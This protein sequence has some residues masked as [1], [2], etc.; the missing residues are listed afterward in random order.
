MWFIEKIKVVYIRLRDCIPSQPLFGV[1]MRMS[2]KVRD[3]R[4]FPPCDLKNNPTSF[5]F[6]LCLTVMESRYSPV[7]N[8]ELKM[9]TLCDQQAKLL[10]NKNHSNQELSLLNHRC[11]SPLIS[12]AKKWFTILRCNRTSTK[13]AESS[14][15]SVDVATP[16]LEIATPSD[17]W[18]IYVRRLETESARDRT[19]HRLITSLSEVV[20]SKFELTR[21]E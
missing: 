19:D 14:E 11:S 2:Q 6:N 12:K 4:N 13:D 1:L 8:R 3:F 16:S 20:I 5:T 17:F 7:F 21:S 10:P 9:W 15:L 18:Q